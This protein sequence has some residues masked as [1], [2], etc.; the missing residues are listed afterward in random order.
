MVYRDKRNITSHTYNEA[1]AIA[2][3]A[4]VP[5]FARDVQSLLRRLRAR[6]AD[7]NA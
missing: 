1:K 6:G 5:D 4:V 7:A 3:A 2:V